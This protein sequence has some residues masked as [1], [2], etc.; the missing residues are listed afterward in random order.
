VSVSYSQLMEGREALEYALRQVCDHVV[1]KVPAD[2]AEFS[3]SFQFI[4]QFAD[5]QSIIYMY[6]MSSEMLLFGFKV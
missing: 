2:H 5:P 6:V 3:D 1:L 4:F